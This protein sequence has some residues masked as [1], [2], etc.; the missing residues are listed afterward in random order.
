MA[1]AAFLVLAREILGIYLVSVVG[2]GFYGIGAATPDVGPKAP[3]T[4]VDR[5][6]SICV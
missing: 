3:L 6:V 4:K 1:V 5:R 2:R